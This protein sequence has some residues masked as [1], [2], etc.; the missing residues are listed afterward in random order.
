MI[1]TNLTLKASPRFR[2]LTEDQV[3]RITRASFE[4]LEK[5]GFKVLHA[6]VRKMLQSA[7]AIVRGESVKVPEFIVRGCLS[8]APKGWTLYDR[9][10]L[11]AMDVAGRN[12]YYGTATASPRTKDALTGE[13]HETRVEDLA[14]AAVVADALENID[15]VMPM[16]SVQDA[17]PQ[18]AEL[19]FN[20][21]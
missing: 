13:Y 20:L 7:G 9:Q 6:G 14:R 5:V 16:G 15:W 21:S 17:P 1:Q 2:M 10:G 18:A 19:H 4:I 11:R 3:E 8:T 12:S